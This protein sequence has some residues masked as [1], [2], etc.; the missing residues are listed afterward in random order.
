MTQFLQNLDVLSAKNSIAV[1]GLQQMVQA[2]EYVFNYWNRMAFFAHDKVQKSA[3]QTNVDDT[4]E[5]SRTM[6]TLLRTLN[7][8]HV[9]KTT[10]E[11]IAT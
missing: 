3:D 10:A 8:I 1:E 9:N 6:L 2:G 4:A 7:I 11:F 5:I